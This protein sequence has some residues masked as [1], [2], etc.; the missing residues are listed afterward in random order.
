[1]HPATHPTMHPPCTPSCRSIHLASACTRTGLAAGTS[2]TGQKLLKQG[3]L[4][5]ELRTA[6]L[7]SDWKKSATWT[8]LVLFL[9][10]ARPGPHPVPHQE[11]HLGRVPWALAPHHH[12]PPPAPAVERACIAPAAAMP[13]GAC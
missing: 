8:N 3:A 9:E 6:L 7:A 2:D 12:R 4:I 1:M 13:A 11:P 10:K 5:I